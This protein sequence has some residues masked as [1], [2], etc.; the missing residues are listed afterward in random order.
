MSVLRYDVFSVLNNHRLVIVLP[1]SKAWRIPISKVGTSGCDT[2]G[3]TRLSPISEVHL[4]E[5]SFRLK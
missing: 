4:Q 5:F 2:I 1:S 3:S